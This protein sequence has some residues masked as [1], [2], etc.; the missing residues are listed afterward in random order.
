MSLSINKKVIEDSATLDAV[1]HTFIKHPRADYI[2]ES[3]IKVIE[4]KAY[5]RERG[6]TYPAE[7]LCIYGDSGTGKTF[8]CEYLLNK[9]PNGRDIHS[10]AEV[11]KH[12]VVLLSVVDKALHALTS[13]VLTA[14]ND[15]YPSR[16]TISHK[17][18]RIQALMNVSETNLLILDEFNNLFSNTNPK[19]IVDW[20]VSLINISHV[21]VLVVGTPEVQKLIKHNPTTSRRFR[22]LK[23]DRFPFD[24]SGDNREFLKYVITYIS[25]MTKTF[26]GLS[27]PDFKNSPPSLLKLYLASM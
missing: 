4:K 26:P 8:I 2:L 3:V 22:M 7:N 1:K 19:A 9:Y 10:T 5:H 15:P 16:G 14:L 23:L 6:N 13:H 11:L 25:R 20:I 21:P 17:T 27:F 24:Y 12:P 18:R